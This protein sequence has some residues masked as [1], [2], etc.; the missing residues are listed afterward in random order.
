MLFI[1]ISSKLS[2]T[3]LFWGIN[4]ENGTLSVLVMLKK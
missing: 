2:F 1:E 3:F 4:Y